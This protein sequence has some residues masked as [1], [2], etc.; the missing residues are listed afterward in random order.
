MIIKLSIVDEEEE[1]NSK[2]FFNKLPNIEIKK[3]KIH[4]DKLSNQVFSQQVVN[5]S[6]LLNRYRNFMNNSSGYLKIMK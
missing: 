5:M 2:V 1:I 6:I 4:C 3:D